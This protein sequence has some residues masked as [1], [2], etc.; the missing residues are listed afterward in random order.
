MS[1]LLLYGAQDPVGDTGKGVP[2]LYK[3]MQKAQLLHLDCQ[4]FSNARHDLF[5]EEANG[6]A[7]AVRHDIAD[8]L[9][10]HF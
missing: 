4:Q 7:E 6:T 5:H 1:V 8:W 3:L 9:S 2:R 10:H